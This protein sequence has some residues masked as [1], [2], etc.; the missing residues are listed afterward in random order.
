MFQL[1]TE[2]QAKPSWLVVANGIELLVK[3]AGT[4]ALLAARR[5]VRNAVRDNPDIET[6]IPFV[7]GFAAWGA[8][9]WKGI[10]DAEGEPLA[11]S[12]EGLAALLRQRPD[13]FQAVDDLYAGP[14]LE[15]LSE[16]KGSSPSPNG[17]SAA[18]PP[19]ATPAPNATKTPPT[20]TSAPT[21][22]TKPEA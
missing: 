4:E 6:Q 8:T 9:D 17:I 2:D 5:E 20:A 13:I 11:F 12:T 18:A 1:Q 21:A 3:P 7:F 22:R 19:T 15:L 10:G 14:V 16:K